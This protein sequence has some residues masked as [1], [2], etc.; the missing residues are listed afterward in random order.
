[1]DAGGPEY[2][3]LKEA[4]D[5]IGS[6]ELDLQKQITK[7]KATVANSDQAIRKLDQEIAKTQQTIKDLE[8]DKL[9]IDEQCLKH[10]R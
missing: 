4:L 6:V 3:G 10:E 7:N 8:R 2:R 1:M 9:A 5:K